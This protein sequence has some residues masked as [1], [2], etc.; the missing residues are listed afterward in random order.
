[1]VF[2]CV[3]LCLHFIHS[4]EAAVM[5][6]AALFDNTAPRLFMHNA[7]QLRYREIACVSSDWQ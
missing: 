4:T 1:M 7:A 3:Y 6:Y 5:Q 2:K